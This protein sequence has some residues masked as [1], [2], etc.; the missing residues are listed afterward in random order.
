[1]ERKIKIEIRIFHFS[2]IGIKTLNRLCIVLGVHERDS[3]RNKNFD[4]Q[5]YF[6]FHQFIVK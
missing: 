4:F 2:R 1:M 3:I 5:N 6:K